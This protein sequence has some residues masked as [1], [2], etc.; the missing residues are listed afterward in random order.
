[1]PR[2]RRRAPGGHRLGVLLPR[3]VAL[4]EGQ[5]A[6][7]FA[8]LDEGEDG[9][10]AVGGEVLDFDAP[11]GQDQDFLARER[12]A[13]MARRSSRFG[14]IDRAIGEAGWKI[15]VLLRLSPAVPFALQ[16]YLYGVTAIR[17]WPCVLTSWLAMLPGTFLYVYL[18]ALGR[19]SLQ[20]AAGGAERPRSSAEWALLI[21][22]L[23]AT[24]AVTV[25]ITVLARRA[26]RQQAGIARE[27]E[28][29]PNSEAGGAGAKGWPWGTTAAAVLALAAL[30]FAVCVQFHPP[31]GRHF[32]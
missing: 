8:L 17:F 10:L 20:A 1:V 9:F 27:G 24:L 4:D 14:A 3:L 13:R 11:R 21:V 26:L 25:Y 19:E 18:G 31:W 2:V 12:V 6:E 28:A 7:E 15:V 22:G 5:L 23:L 16:N 30:A 32:R 29:G